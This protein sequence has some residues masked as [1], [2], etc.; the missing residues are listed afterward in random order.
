[1]LYHVILRKGYED[2]SG[3]VVGLGSAGDVLCCEHNPDAE[4]KAIHCHVV[5]ETP[6][7]DEAIRKRIKTSGLGG[8]GQYAIM[9]KTK[10]TQQPYDRKELLKYVLK[11]QERQ[12]PRQSELKYSKGFT[13][14]EVSE[15]IEKWIPK[16]DD[17]NHDKPQE[18]KKNPTTHYDLI[19]MIYA[20]A[21]KSIRIVRDEFGNLINEPCIENSVA[22]WHLMCR[23]LNEHKVRTSSNELERFYVTLLR[24]DPLHQENL[25]SNLCK[26]LGW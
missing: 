4:E 9:L 16:N 24:H 23:T 8:R 14:E 5:V 25:Y 1:M 11:G 22:T 2:V 13:T 12:T 19:E 26:K 15:A 3:L 17:D 6:I 7:T 21:N 10:K 18:K 20:K